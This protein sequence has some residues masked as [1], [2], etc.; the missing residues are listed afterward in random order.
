MNAPTDVN[1]D[2]LRRIE[3]LERSN[4]ELRAR[5]NEQNR[6]SQAATLLH[7]SRGREHVEQISF[8]TL[9]I[10]TLQDSRN[11]LQASESRLRESERRVRAS[12]KKLRQ[13]TDN[14][15]ALIAYVDADQRYRFNNKA[16]ET[17]LLQSPKELFGVHLREATGEQ[18]YS[19]VKPFID[20]VLSGRRAGHEWWAQLPGG[21][22]YVKS[23]YI[24]DLR[25][26]GS[27]A[28]FYVLAS[29]LTD[30]KQS[31][32][33][34]SDSEARL[35]LAIDAGRMAIW[36]VDTATNEITSSPELNRLLGLPPGVT[37]TTD[38]IR[39]RYAPG[40]RTRLRRVALDA[41]ARG[42]CYAE[43]ELHVVWPDGSHRWLL[44]RA[45]MQGVKKGVP[46][47]T[48]GVALDITG[49][50]KG[51]EHQQLLINELNHRVKNTLTTVQ[52]IVNQSLRNASTAEEARG[53][54][55]GRLL[56]LSRAHDVL[57][58]ENWGGAYLRE[59]VQQAIE[60]FQ[61]TG[62]RF[63]ISGADTRLPPRIALAIAMA[64]QELGT[65]AAKYGALSNEAGRI[66]IEWSVQEEQHGQRL[67]M[68]WREMDGPS[69]TP[70]KR[71]GFGTR[72]VERSLAHELN[73]AVSIDFAP[74]GVVCTINAPLA[75]S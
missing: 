45:E 66:V 56:A 38:D 7:E 44:L 3:E 67:R 50:K 19:R 70:P 48:I 25:E 65:N 57:T 61:E 54:V 36:E 68:L 26:D 17:W 55:E 5:L 8:A 6:L 13:I 58:R 43:T 63:R 75:E 30:V 53:A 74:A 34:L 27:V 62:N 23:E 21:L 4:Q 46:A 40:E 51:E 47:R 59:V 2:L 52:S 69:V 73:G 71:R 49:R 39:Q 9:R 24:P 64:I 42:E 31:Q 14:L 72:L 28:G 15:P 16:Y 35:R 10:D 20:S 33:A 12:E 60:P 32:A 29:D 11:S 41:L 37:P 1:Y 22:R 18:A